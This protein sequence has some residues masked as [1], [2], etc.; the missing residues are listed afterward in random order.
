MNWKFLIVAA[1]S[2]AAVA[3]GSAWQ[4]QA[5]R[6]KAT[7]AEQTTR[8]AQELATWQDALRRINEGA[9][10]Q[11]AALQEQQREQAAAL[12]QIDNQHYQELR[13]AQNENAR[14][15]ADIAAG[16][17]RVPVGAVCPA[18]NISAGD[19][20]DTANP[21]RLDDG[22]VRAEL[23]PEVARHLVR[24]TRDADE[25][26]RKLKGLQAWTQAALPPHQLHGE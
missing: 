17:V 23:H 8:H 12:T 26:A 7:M 18:N 13:R 10:L 9:A 6:Y 25:C 3:A 21:T 19:V 14:L 5:W 11:L 2:G 15:R 1:I 16:R 24:I 20:S 22:T 4:I